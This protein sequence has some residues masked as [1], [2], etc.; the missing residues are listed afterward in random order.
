MT[1]NGR[2]LKVLAL[3][4]HDPLLFLLV[5][6]LAIGFPTIVAAQD[7]CVRAPGG[8]SPNSELNTRVGAWDPE[9]FYHLECRG[10]VVA[11]VVARQTT[12]GDDL[13]EDSNP[14]GGPSWTFRS[15]PI[16]CRRD[17]YLF[18]PPTSLGGLPC[19]SIPI[20]DAFDPLPLALKLE[21]ELPPPDLRIAMNPARGLVR[22]PTWF[23]VE[24]YDGG[25]LSQTETVLESHQVCHFV[26]LRD[27]DGHPLLDQDGRPRTRRDCTIEHTTFTVDVQLVPS[28]FSWDFG[29]T[30]GRD[31]ACTAG[32]S[33]CA[34]ALGQPYLDP[35]HPSPIQHPYRWSS[36]GVSIRGA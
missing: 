18:L 23:W 31:I 15:V 36:P 25:A 26:V 29:D 3:T 12:P 14:Q 22:L 8:T 11:S 10:G 5:S 32:E 30:A 16:F 9:A 21:A 28:Q 24:G 2:W 20:N 7:R 13:H 34:D 33:S 4:K 6:V 19:A 1:A 35:T 27:A 17:D